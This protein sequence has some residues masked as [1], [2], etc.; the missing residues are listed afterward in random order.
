MIL[1]RLLI[2]FFS[3]SLA[4]FQKP[5]DDLRE[6]AYKSK[7]MFQLFVDSF[8]DYP[9]PLIAAVNGPSVGIMTTI[10]GLFDLVVCSEDATFHTPFSALAIT[11]EGCATYTF[12]KIF[13]PSK[14]NEILM[15]N[16]KLSSKEALHYG[17]VSRVISKNEWEKYLEDFF[18]S[19]NGVLKTCNIASL[20]KTKRLLRDE[21]TT[22]NLRKTNAVEAEVLMQCW[23][24]PDFIKVVSKF[25][26]K[27]ST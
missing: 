2:Y 15:F 24:E 19:D 8:I 27:K 23:L 22:A 3:F 6:L 11:P 16:Y 25:L 17:F 4:N 18:Y 26:S 5:T 10:L 9:K 1:T 7:K 12:P 20:I 14:A 21:Q 13:G